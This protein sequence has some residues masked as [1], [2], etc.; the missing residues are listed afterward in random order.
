MNPT[1][2]MNP[3][4][5]QGSWWGLVGWGPTDAPTIAQPMSQTQD[6]PPNE[7]T[8]QEQTSET[9]VVADSQPR[10]IDVL[11]TTSLQAQ[12]DSSMSPPETDEDRGSSWLSP[13]SW[14]GSHNQPPPAPAPAPIVQAMEGIEI[15]EQAQAQHP[16]NTDPDIKEARTTLNS[17][18]PTAQAHMEPT[19]P[20]QSSIATNVSG[21]ASFFSSKTLLA[22]RITDVEYR[23]ENTMEVMEIDDDDE[24]RAGT[25]TL[26]ATSEARTGNDAARETQ[27]AT[28]KI[29]PA[30]PR[31]PSPLPKPNV[32]SDKKPDE[33]KGSKRV[34]V[35]PAPSKASGRASPRVPAPPNL[36]LPT[37]EDTFRSPPRSTA[38]QPETSSAFTKTVRFVSGMLFAAREDGTSTGKGKAPSSSKD[39]HGSFADFGRDLP[40]AWDVIGDRLD[41]DILRGCRRVV[42]IGIHGWFPGTSV[43]CPGEIRGNEADCLSVCLGLAL[44]LNRRD[45]ADCVRRGS[46]VLISGAG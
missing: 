27:V 44:L 26:V 30:P 2:T 16:S 42:V 39:D 40:R 45:H 22:K 33:I 35:S 29:G 32:K 28:T 11:N 37:W 15:D 8:D 43:R 7:P 14:Y 25:A 46:F 6:A 23:E 19:N 21:W 9:T 24:E 31:S 12:P 18:L 3:T 17:V 10:G 20:I 1:M 13:W 36:V 41:G 5:T 34:S 38:M 4:Q